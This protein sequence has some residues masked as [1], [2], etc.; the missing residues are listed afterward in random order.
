MN[1]TAEQTKAIKRN[2]NFEY[3]LAKKKKKEFTVKLR[4]TK[5]H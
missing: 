4:N 2:Q 5:V 1:E 3:I